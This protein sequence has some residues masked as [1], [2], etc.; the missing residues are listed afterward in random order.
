[1]L[2]RGSLGLGLV[3]GS[4]GLVRG[5]LE[6][7][8]GSLG[9]LLVRGSLGLVRGSLGLVME[10]LG[11]VRVSLGLVRGSLGLVK[12]FRVHVRVRGRVRIKWG[13]EVIISGRGNSSGHEN[14]HYDALGCSAR[15]NKF[16]YI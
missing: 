16:A 4:L 7:V 5:S 9:L 15:L 13:S 1:M 14:V 8:R 10:S 2:V 6:L 11:L 12:D 3:R